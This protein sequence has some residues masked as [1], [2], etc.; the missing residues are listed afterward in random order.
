MMTGDQWFS[1][2]KLV[3][4]LGFALVVLYGVYKI[5]TKD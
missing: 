1:L 4:I 3:V 2:L 5:M